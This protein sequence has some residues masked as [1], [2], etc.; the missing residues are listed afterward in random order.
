MQYQEIKLDLQQDKHIFVQGDG[1]IGLTADSPSVTA[2]TA[3]SATELI[4]KG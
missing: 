3:I 2:G 1:T 4:V